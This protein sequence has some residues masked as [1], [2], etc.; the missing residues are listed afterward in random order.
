MRGVWVFGLVV[1]SGCLAR[2]GLGPGRVGARRSP[3]GLGRD[4]PATFL[5]FAQGLGR[6]VCRALAG[7]AWCF[8]SRGGSAG[9]FVAPGPWVSPWA[10][11][12][13]PVGV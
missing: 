1:W 11:E 3:D 10:F 8:A 7:G 4:A 6:G 13:H 2:A 9:F 5:G 12:F